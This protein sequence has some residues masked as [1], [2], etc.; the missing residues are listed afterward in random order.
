MITKEEVVK[1]AKLARLELTE[2]EIKKMQ[3]DLS[4]I[5]DYFELLKKAGRHPTSIQLDRRRVS[6]QLRKDEVMP[7]KGEVIE[8]IIQA[9]PDKKDDY[10]RVKPI[11]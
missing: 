8:K 11:L 5:L 9:F 1:I 4:S 2:E 10:I 6:N 7:Q 3:K